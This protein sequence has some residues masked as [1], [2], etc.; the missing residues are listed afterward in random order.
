M[1]LQ[2]GPNP[3]IAKSGNQIKKLS[4]Q[5]KDLIVQGDIIDLIPGNYLFIFVTVG[6]VHASLSKRDSSFLRKEKD[7]VKRSVQLSKGIDIFLKMNLWKGLCRFCS[8]CF[9]G[10]YPC[11]GKMAI[12]LV[13]F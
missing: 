8:K 12:I 9:A 13:I 5:D 4:I 11:F 3:V 7:M 2:E 6:N 1:T 10:M